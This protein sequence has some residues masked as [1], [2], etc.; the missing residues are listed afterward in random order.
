M[1]LVTYFTE[2]SPHVSETRKIDKVI[3]VRRITVKRDIALSFPDGNNADRK[4][5]DCLSHGKSL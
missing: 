3:D 4:E 2:V 5:C 1:F